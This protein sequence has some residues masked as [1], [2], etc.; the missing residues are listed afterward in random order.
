MIPPPRPPSPE[1]WRK[2]CV[3]PYPSQKKCVLVFVRH[4]PPQIWDL[5]AGRMIANFQEHI[6]PV[7]SVQF[8]PKEFLLATGSSDRTAKFWDLEKF[9]MISQTTP[10]A[11][12]IRLV[13]GGGLLYCTYCTG[14]NPHGWFNTL[15]IVFGGC[16]LEDHSLIPK[17]L[18]TYTVT[19]GLKGFTSEARQDAA[20]L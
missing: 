17:S 2:F 7:M 16:F 10:E 3:G 12:G 15:L 18:K 20:P 9:E 4:P 13:T 6:G 5:S 11:S 1:L 14:V 8:H 19:F